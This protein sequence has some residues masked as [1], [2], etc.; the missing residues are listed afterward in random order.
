MAEFVA[1]VSSPDS[2]YV[3]LAM[4]GP[5]SIPTGAATAVAHLP[6]TGLHRT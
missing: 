6:L 3:A 1:H 5:N 4:A 2:V